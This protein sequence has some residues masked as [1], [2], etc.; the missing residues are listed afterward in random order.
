M[1]AG[2]LFSAAVG[3][4]ATR[5]RNWD[6]LLAIQPHPNET[7]IGTGVNLLTWLDSHATN[8]LLIYVGRTVSSG[9]GY[10]GEI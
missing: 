7:T 8:R 4:L 5:T 10:R 2:Y 9:I 6:R 1:E 3:V